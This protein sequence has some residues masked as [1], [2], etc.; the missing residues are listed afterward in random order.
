MCPL[1]I[2]RERKTDT[3]MAC[4]SPP[5]LVVPPMIAYPRKCTME[6]P[7]GRR[8]S[9]HTISMTQVGLNIPPLIIP[10]SLDVAV[11]KPFKLNF[12]KEWI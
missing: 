12:N 9:G 4:V 8:S 11:L 7:K 10:P 2:S 3:V 6:T 5:G 1:N